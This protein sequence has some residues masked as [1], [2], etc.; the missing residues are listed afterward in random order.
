MLS[1]LK[2]LKLK[3]PPIAQFVAVALGM[4]LIAK[5][6]P[7]LSI[8]IPARL[9]LVVLFICVAACV[10]IPAVAAFRT[11]GTTVEPRRPERASRLVTDGVYR[12]SRN[13]MYLGLLC[14]LIAWALYLSNMLGFA[15]LPLFVVSMNYLQIHV[16][17]QAMEA[18]FA[19]EYR[20]YRNSVRRWI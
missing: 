5:S 9:A 17:E 19:E 13:P 2:A 20:D 10:A 8:D 15:A 18:Q 11:A 14:L 1:P 6:T 12:F 3:I 16:E 4:W 7:A